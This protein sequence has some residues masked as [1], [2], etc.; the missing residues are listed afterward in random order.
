MI[1]WRELENQFKEI[2]LKDIKTKSMKKGAVLLSNKWFPAAHLD[3][4]VAR[5]LHMELLCLGELTDIHQYAWINPT[6]KKLQRGDDAYCIIPSNYYYD[7]QANYSSHFDIKLAPQIIEQKRNGLSCRIFYVW[8]L[9]N[10][11][12]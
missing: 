7:V 4:Y 3:Y 11:K 1:G 10:Y 8:R 6:R 9:K 12:P 2:Q 5:P